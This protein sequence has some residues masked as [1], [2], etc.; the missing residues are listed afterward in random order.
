[1]KLAFFVQLPNALGFLGMFLAGKRRRAGWALG[2]VS[3]FAWALWAY[4]DHATGIYPWCV[5]WGLVYARNWWL[6]RPTRET[7]N[8]IS[9]GTS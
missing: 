2:L 8:A 4:L 6:W 3:E 9:Q 1:V 7:G 5:V